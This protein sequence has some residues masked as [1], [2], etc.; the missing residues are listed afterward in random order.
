MEMRPIAHIETD[1]PQKFGIPRNS[2]APAPAGR[3]VFEP[4]VRAPAG[5]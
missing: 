4:G 3:I 2:F 5:G 1:P